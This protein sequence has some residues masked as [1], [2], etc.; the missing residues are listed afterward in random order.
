MKTRA[1]ATL[2]DGKPDVHVSKGTPDEDKNVASAA[3]V[4]K[5]FETHD[6]KG[7]AETSADNI[8]WTTSPLPRRMNARRRWSPTSRCDQAIPD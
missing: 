6:A 5:M 4:Q 1:L 3:A 7:F 8:T 2:P